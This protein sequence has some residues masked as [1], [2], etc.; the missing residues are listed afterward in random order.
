MEVY[1]LAVQARILLLVGLGWIGLGLW[2]GYDP[3][4]I[5]WR[6]AIGAMLAMWIAGWLVRQVVAVLEERMAADMAERQL[7]AEKAVAAQQANPGQAPGRLA[8]AGAKG[9]SA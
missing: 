9:R 7:V 5:A 1:V 2:Q 3:A 8:L 4:T 6:A